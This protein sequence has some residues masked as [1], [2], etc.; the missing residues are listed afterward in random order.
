MRKKSLLMLFASLVLMSCGQKN[1]AWEKSL[2]FIQEENSQAVGDLKQLKLVDYTYKGKIKSEEQKIQVID[3]MCAD[4]AP[5]T[6]VL[7]TIVISDTTLTETDSIIKQR[8]FPV[9]EITTIR[10]AIESGKLSAASVSTVRQLLMKNLPIGADFLNLV[11]DYKGVKYHT[12]AVVDSVVVTDLIIA[13][14]STGSSTFIRSIR[15]E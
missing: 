12:T 9:F 6:S 11:W 4:E 7:S 15:K 1:S 8:T 14:L 13:H 2:N 5:I 3:A 10:Q